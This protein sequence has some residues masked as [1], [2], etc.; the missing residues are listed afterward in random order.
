MSGLQLGGEAGSSQPVR[1]C[2]QR[3]AQGLSVVGSALLIDGRA[4]ASKHLN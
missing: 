1:G 4:V 3:A 2:E